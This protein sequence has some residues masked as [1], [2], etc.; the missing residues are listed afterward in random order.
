MLTAAIEDADGNVWDLKDVDFSVLV[1]D[2]SL[3][4]FCAGLA[5]DGCADGEED[6]LIWI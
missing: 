6:M 3:L 4:R 5:G 1:H 2:C